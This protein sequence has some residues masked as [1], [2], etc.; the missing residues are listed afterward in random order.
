M[1]VSDDSAGARGL[2]PSIRRRPAVLPTV[3]VA[4][5]CFGVT[6]E[7]LA[8]QLQSG[9]DP[10]LGKTTAAS[11]PAKVRPRRK[12]II[13]KVVSAATGGTYQAT[14]S[15]GSSLPASPAPVSTST[16]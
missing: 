16:S 10:A 13:T 6:F 3:L 11:S 14:S 15:S 8:F 5:A 7:F 4:L 12:I 1:T 2:R 9:H